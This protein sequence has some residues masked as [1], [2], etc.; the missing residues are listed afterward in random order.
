MAFVI[1]FLIVNLMPG[2]KARYSYPLFCLVFIMLGWLLSVQPLPSTVEKIWKRILLLVLPL[3][4][5]I[6][7]LCLAVAGLN[8]FNAFSAVSPKIAEMLGPLRNP[9]AVFSV[10]ISSMMIAAYA[11]SVLKKR[12]SVSGYWMLAT[13]SGLT[14]VCI[15][16]VCVFFVF[17]IVKP[18][19]SR[20]KGKLGKELSTQIK[21]DILYTYQIEC[22]PFLFYVR[23]RVEFLV[24][25]GQINGNVRFLLSQKELQDELW[26]N[27]AVSARN[28]REIF[29]FKIKKNEYRLVE[30]SGK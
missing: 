8:Y 1:S 16:F 18:E 4:S 26:K 6:S 29:K 15:M 24:N 14:A 25:P 28:P 3:I 9:A 12:G 21:G 20:V 19:V 7:L 11:Y 17:P 2:A 27:D 5:F 22:E 13:L 23:P 10:F 30:L